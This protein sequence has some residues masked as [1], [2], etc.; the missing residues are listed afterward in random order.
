M[1]GSV[2]AGLTARS[3][4]VSEVG[5]AREGRGIAADALQRPFV[6]RFRFRA[7][8][9]T[10]VD[11]ISEVSEVIISRGLRRKMVYSRWGSLVSYALEQPL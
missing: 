4:A 8:L 7:R 2:S 6:P 11:M 9:S 1:I 10:S 3:S 5:T